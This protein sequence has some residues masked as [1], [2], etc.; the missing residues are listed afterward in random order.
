MGLDMYLSKKTYV[1]SWDHTPENKEYQVTVL[2][3]GKPVPKTQIDPT[4][5]SY[6]VEDV[7]YWRKANEIHNWFVKTVQSGNDNGGSYY[8]TRENLEVLLAD[9]NTVLD[10]KAN[11]SNYALK[12]PEAVAKG[13][14][15]TASG[16]FFGSTEYDEYYWKSLKDTKKMLTKALKDKHAEEFEYCASW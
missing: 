2:R 16:F 8:V 7:A 6:I 3:G 9:V 13:V 12:S 15:P 11:A 10:A 4:K 5:I 1:K 14:L